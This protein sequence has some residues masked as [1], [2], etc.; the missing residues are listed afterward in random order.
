MR[1]DYRLGHLSEADLSPDPFEQFG[2]WLDQSCQADLLEPNAMTLATVDA[3][4]REALLDARLPEDVIAEL[5][6]YGHPVSLVADEPG[7]ASNFSRP[8]A[9]TI[10]YATGRLRAGVDPFRPTLAL[11]Y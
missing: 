2:Q 1:V 10:D 6:S 3:S 4:G 7:L 8:S 5:Q 9:V 11:G